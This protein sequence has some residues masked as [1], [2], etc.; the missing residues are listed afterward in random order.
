MRLVPVYA[1]LISMVVG[2]FLFLAIGCDRSADQPPAPPTTIA[3]SATPA[4]S[5]R[6]GP[7]P[8]PTP[9]PEPTP[10]PI[11]PT[12]TPVPTPTPIPTATPV[13]VAPTPRPTP[14][15]RNRGGTLN[16]S[17]SENI[18][19]LDVHM[20]VSPALSTWGPGIA[21]S[22][23]LRLRSG[24]DVTLPSMAV[25]C[26]LCVSW[27]MESPTTY[28]F[29]LRPDAL[30]HDVEPVYARPVTAGDIVY[31][32]LRQSDS[33]LPNSPL[34]HNIDELREIDPSTIRVTL[35]A[36][37][38]DALLAFADGHSK[39][40]AREAVE[41]GGDLRD[42]PTIGSGPWV[43]EGSK[44]D[45][46]HKFSP[47]ERYYEQGLPLVQRLNILVLT[48]EDTRNAAFQTGMIDVMNMQPD[49]WL[50][51]TRR[52]PNAPFMKAPQPGVGVEVA[53]KT[54]VPPFD[55]IGVRRAAML[56]MEPV[57]AIKEH[58]GGFGFIGQGFAVASPQW[59]IPQNE[60]AR[61]FDRRLDA[62]NALRSSGVASPI[63]IVLT[64][65]DFGPSYTSHAHA[66]SVELQALGFEVETEIVNRREF[67]ERVWLGGEY[68]LMV[69]PPAPITAP[70]GY[71]LPVLHSSGIWNT[72]GHRDNVLDELL[73]S[74]AVE[75]DPET[76]ADLVRSIQERVLDQ[77]YRFMPAARE[78]I[79][80]WRTSVRDFH[81]NFS[82]YEYHHWARVWLDG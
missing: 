69:G 59:L 12:K 35:D 52:F 26:D 41:L 15:S 5:S 6:S 74:Q 14:D 9:S 75:Y 67:G 8:S 25:E 57:K 42:G 34:L 63:P 54:T 80:T 53:F 60:L 30:W 68:Q 3:P 33:E 36:P 51:Y 72:T 81:P 18:A 19:H 23:L 38:A 17:T 31:S 22:R 56:G 77:G 16:L 39:I 32:Y 78:A 2:C 49:E 46:R 11:P 73:E 58:W 44:P 4:M 47:N 10:T 82:A 55:D 50:T 13:P 65:G 62:E 1:A 21:Y 29:E 20:D 79:W 45:D 66:I 7:V 70:N 71:L 64:V 28:K 40:V 43:L 76:R 24:S 61:R 37:D 48:G 27:T